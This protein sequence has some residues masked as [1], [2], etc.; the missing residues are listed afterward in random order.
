MNTYSRGEELTKPQ[1]TENDINPGRKCPAE[2][3]MYQYSG[4]SEPQ[5]AVN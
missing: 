1:T 2:L 5:G 4:N 3:D